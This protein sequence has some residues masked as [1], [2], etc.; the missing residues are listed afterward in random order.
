[1]LGPPGP[2]SRKC[3]SATWLRPLTGPLRSGLVGSKHA[4]PVGRGLTE[5]FMP[6]LDRIAAM[7]PE[8]AAWRRD[9]HAHPEILFDGDFVDEGPQ[10]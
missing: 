1:M 2:A 4:A 5:H 8:V 9:I 6:I 10:S 7:Q 3:E